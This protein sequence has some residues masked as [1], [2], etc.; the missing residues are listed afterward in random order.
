MGFPSTSGPRPRCVP[1]GEAGSV[2]V[3][4]AVVGLLLVL[5]MA[6]GAVGIGVVAHMQATGAADAAALAAAPVTFRPF[7]ASGSPSAEASRF[8]R[9]NGAE[10][11]SCTCSIDRMWRARTVTVLVVRRM[12]VPGLGSITFNA[13]SRATFDPSKLVQPPA[14]PDLHDR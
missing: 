4:A 9:Y 12:P 10:L 7:G 5:V 3:A 2:V 11:V 6:I 13:E 8:A 1:S 14:V